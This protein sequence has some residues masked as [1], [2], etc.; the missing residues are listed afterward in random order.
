MCNKKGT[1]NQQGQSLM[2]LIVVVAVTVFVVAALTFATIASLRNAQFSKNQAQATKLA[3]EALEKIRTGRDR[4]QCIR[5]IP[6]TD[7]NSWNGGNSVCGGASSF[8]SYPIYQGCGS[9][10]FSCYFRVYQDTLDYI[11]SSQTFPTVGTEPIPSDN[12][13]FQRVAIISDDS[14]T[15]QTQKTVTSIVIWT[16]VSGPHE[17]RLTTILRKI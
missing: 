15:F 16:D 14:T 11:A 12:P 1:V 2:E 8:W 10:P 17:S 7:V 5:N 13:I 3:Q 6:S 4:N 9:S